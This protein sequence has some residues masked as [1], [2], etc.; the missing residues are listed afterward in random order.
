MLSGAFAGAHRQVLSLKPFVMCHP[1]STK[2]GIEDSLNPWEIPAVPFGGA[3]PAPQQG[4]SWRES[5]ILCYPLSH[6][7]SRLG[8]PSLR[9]PVLQHS[10]KT[11]GKKK[12]WKRSLASLFCKNS[13]LGHTS[14]G[15]SLSSAILPCPA[16]GSWLTDTPCSPP[17]QRS[18]VP[19]DSCDIT[20]GLARAQPCD[21]LGTAT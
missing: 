20:G 1:K 14:L 5:S 13:G 7:G 9:N 4:P 17:K 8:S 3:G 21:S 2:R 6:G 15:N 11:H 19:G 12:I 18:G 16:H 10:A